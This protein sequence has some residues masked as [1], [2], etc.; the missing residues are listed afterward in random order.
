MWLKDIER[1]FDAKMCPEESRLAFAVY[2]VT[3][4]AE[5]WWIS[6]KSIMEEMKEP[7]TW[8]VF[9][10][11]FIFEYFPGSIKYAKEVEFLQLTQGA[12][13]VAEYAEKFKHFSCFYTMPLDEELRCKKFENDLSGDLRLI[14]VPLSIKD[15]VALVE[16][17]RVM[18]KMKVEVETQHPS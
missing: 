7:V 2:M 12:K 4:E 6:M 5:H 17:A 14:V 11:K 1:I 10:R 9:R 8:D 15:F 18:E 16:K 13:F 3:G